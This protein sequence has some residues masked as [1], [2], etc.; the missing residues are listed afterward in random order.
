MSRLLYRLSYSAPAGDLDGAT[1]GAPI[2]NRTLDLL[3]TMETLCRLSYRGR[4]PAS[5]LDGGVRVHGPRR[6]REI[7]EPGH[8]LVTDHP[9]I[10][11]GPMPG[12]ACPCASPTSSA[13][14]AAPVILR[15]EARAATIPAKIG[16]ENDVP[17]HRAMPKNL[18][19]SPL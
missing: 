8:G 2:G 19:N 4:L 1:G 15:A 10:S 6:R 11:S 3:L 18:R 5:G 13:A 12:T 17:L 9:G 16:V 7:V 14:A